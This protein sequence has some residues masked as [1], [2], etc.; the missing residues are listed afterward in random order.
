MAEK[1]RHQKEAKPSAQ[2]LVEEEKL[3]FF[4]SWRNS[5]LGKLSLTID[6][7]LLC[8]LMWHGERGWLP[9]HS[10]QPER[11]KSQNSHPKDTKMEKCLKY[12]AYYV[13]VIPQQ[14]I[15][16]NSTSL[17]SIWTKIKTY[18]CFQTTGGN[19]IDISEFFLKSEEW[20]DTLYKQLIDFFLAHLQQEGRGIRHQGDTSVDLQPTLEKSL[21]T[22]TSFSWW[23]KSMASNVGDKCWWP[24]SRIWPSSWGRC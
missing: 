1:D 17:L 6:L 22:L 15:V 5:I 7:E 24:L 18:L 8:F 13:L 2:W 20:Q 19:F 9:P 16:W 14:T 11:R 23:N 4:N 21:F 12:V 10:W 3:S